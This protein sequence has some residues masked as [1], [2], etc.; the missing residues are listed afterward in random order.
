MAIP[1]R[2]LIIEM[3][4]IISDAAHL[5][6]IREGVKEI[7]IKL[8]DCPDENGKIELPQWL[9][10][11]FTRIQNA[12]HI[13]QLKFLSTGQV[14][15]V[16]PKRRS[17]R[18]IFIM[19]IY[20]AHRSYQ[21][22]T[23]DRVHIAM[24]NKLLNALHGAPFETLHINL[25]LSEDTKTPYVW[26][27]GS[28]FTSRFVNISGVHSHT[29]SHARAILKHHSGIITELK[30]SDIHTGLAFCEEQSYHTKTPKSHAIEELTLT[31]MTLTHTLNIMATLTHAN[32]PQLRIIIVH[33]DSTPDVSKE[34]NMYV[35]QW[36]VLMQKLPLLRMFI[37]ITPV[38][39]YLGSSDHIRAV[40]DSSSFENYYAILEH[41]IAQGEQIAIQSKTEYNPKEYKKWGRDK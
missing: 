34:F 31:K 10:T 20:L 26:H 40:I 2:L 15:Y 35:A 6:E 11:L 18:D 7:H 1:H 13:Q 38:A 25:R 19:N 12:Q 23:F 33:L 9:F 17:M 22:I 28:P 4:N 16:V 29:E 24:V 14:C 32:W 36:K 37:V 30:L 8:A 41:H 3:T 39:T 21:K 27:K 5:N